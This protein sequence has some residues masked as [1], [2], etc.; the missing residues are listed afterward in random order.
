MRIRRKTCGAAIVIAANLSC[1]LAWGPTY[2]WNVANGRCLFWRGSVKAGNGG[3][4]ND[5]VR[6]S[7]PKHN[8]DLNLNR[9]PLFLL[10]SPLRSAGTAQKERLRLR[11]RGGRPAFP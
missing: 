9:N 2:H 7:P 6:T 10:L 4:I 5:R 3:E 8:R 11:L 1:G